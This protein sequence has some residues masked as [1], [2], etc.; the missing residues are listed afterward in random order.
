[1]SYITSL[2]EQ[3]HVTLDGLLRCPAGLQ[4]AVGP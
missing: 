2:V 3:D 4:G 1:M